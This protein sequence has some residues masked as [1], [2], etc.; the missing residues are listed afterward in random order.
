MYFF[1]SARS[2]SESSSGGRVGPG[3]RADQVDLAPLRV[4][5]REVLAGVATARLLP[6]QRGAGGALRDQEHVAQVERQV[7][8]RVEPASARRGHLA[9]PF[10]DVGEQLERLFQLGLAPD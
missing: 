10:P 8:A 1:S 7:P 2:N 3:Q 9:D 5:L 6:F 4:H